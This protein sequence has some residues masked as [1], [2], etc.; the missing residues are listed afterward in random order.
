MNIVLTIPP[1]VI[2]T[3]I[4]GTALIINFIICTIVFIV[5][6]LIMFL[7]HTEK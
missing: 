2:C 6:L 1:T 3:L 5:G 7:E 4:V